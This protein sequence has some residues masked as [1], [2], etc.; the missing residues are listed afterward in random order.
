MVQGPSC[1]DGVHANV[2]FDAKHPSALAMYC[3]DGRF[4]E[5]I[6]ELLHSL[7]HARLD[8]LT[9]PGG[10][11]LLDMTSSS[12]SALEV[13][14]SA[15]TFL[16]RGHAI[17]HIVLLGHEGCGYYKARFPYESAD[18][19]KRRQCADL[20]QAARWVRGEH[21]ALHVTTYFATPEGTR[22]RFDEV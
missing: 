15:A 10:P 7:G 18:A 6:E 21:E 19:M 1:G 3:S 9:V 22:I 17:K 5:A 2:T 14:R 12:L 4:T 8:T 20:A 13:M 11:A 16:I